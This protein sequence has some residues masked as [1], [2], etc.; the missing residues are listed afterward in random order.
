LFSI[1]DLDALRHGG[2]G[3]LFGQVY[4]PSTLGAFLREFRFGHVR[5]LDSVARGLL[6]R[7]AATTPLL[8]R[9]RDLD[10]KGKQGGGFGHTKVGG[11]PVPR[12]WW[13]RR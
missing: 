9:R 11:Y 8:H 3:E 1:A 2:M 10:L 13:P 12:R 4:E 5:Q 7:L 6:V